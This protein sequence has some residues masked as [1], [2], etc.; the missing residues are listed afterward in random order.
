MADTDW[1]FFDSLPLVQVDWLDANSSSLWQ[2]LDALLRDVGPI[3]VH[4]IGR[5]VK[6]EPGYVMLV[7]EASAQKDAGNR[8]VIPRGCIQKITYL[9]SKEQPKY[10]FDTITIPIPTIDGATTLMPPSNS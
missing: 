4:S 9:V 6:D 8:S 2:D 3:V 7:S 1:T 10:N 5:L